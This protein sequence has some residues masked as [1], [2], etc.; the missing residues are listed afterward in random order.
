M[1]E[2]TDTDIES[3]HKIAALI[4]FVTDIE[5][6]ILDMDH[7]K[8]IL[9]LGDNHD[10]ATTEEVVAAV[11]SKKTKVFSVTLSTNDTT[12]NVVQFTDGAAGTV[13]FEVEFGANI[14]GVAK[15]VAVPGHLFE[16]S[17]N[18]ALHIKLSAAVKV[19]YSISY[20]QEA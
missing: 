14:Q 3:I 19:T 20:F 7:G 17:V 4:D 13:L 12:T 16:T 9:S 8:T 2:L 18:T 5:V 10:T 15:T 1:A 6:A 11:A